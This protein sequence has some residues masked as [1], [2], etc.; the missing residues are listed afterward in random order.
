MDN[1]LGVS[2]RIAKAFQTSAMTPLLAIVG[3]LM[4]V[5]AVMVTPKEEEPQIDVTFADVYIPFP[6][7]SPAEVESLVTNPAEQIISEI[8][9]IDK[10]YSFSQPDG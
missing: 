5:F 2:G 8:E 1:R 3:L 6:G 7:A 10:I 9:G 4:G